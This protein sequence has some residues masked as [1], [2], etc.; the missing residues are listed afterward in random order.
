MKI[1]GIDYG[2]KKL[3]LAIGDTQSKLAEPLRVVKFETQQE[4]LRKLGQILRTEQIKK[5]VVGVSEGDMAQKTKR[6]GR[7]LSEKQ[8]VEIYYQDETLTTNDAQR[9]SI[10][11]GI[12]RKKRRE[13]ED[14][15]A[16]ALILQAYFDRRA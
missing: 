4:A 5:A 2:Q 9:L 8:D 15:Y 6:F 10:K 14:A 7:A 11:A 3:G 1:L 12:K 13:M 16:A